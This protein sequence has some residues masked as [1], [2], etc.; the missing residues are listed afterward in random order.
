MTIGPA[1][2]CV[3][4]KHFDQEAPGRKCAAFPDGI[5]DDI[6]DSRFDHRKAHSGDHGIRFELAPGEPE[7]LIETKLNMIFGK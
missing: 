5:P 3:S 6:W 2:M 7:G 1:P 4:C